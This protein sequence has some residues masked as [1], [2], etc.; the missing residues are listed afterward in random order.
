MATLFVPIRMPCNLAIVIQDNTRRVQRS[1]GR[2]AILIHQAGLF[3]QG[4]G[5][6]RDMAGN[7]GKG[8]HP[9]PRLHAGAPSMSSPGGMAHIGNRGI[10]ITGSKNAVARPGILARRIQGFQHNQ[11]CWSMVPERLT[12][13]KTLYRS[14]SPCDGK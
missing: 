2:S 13:K 9:C 5:H 14:S 11:L 8:A 4:F 12:A 3:K 10:V 7:M 6:N 1:L